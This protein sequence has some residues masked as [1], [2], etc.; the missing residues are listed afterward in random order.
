MYR[1]RE[2]KQFISDDPEDVNRQFRTVSNGICLKGK[3]H[4]LLIK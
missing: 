1:I 4:L 3:G 2:Q